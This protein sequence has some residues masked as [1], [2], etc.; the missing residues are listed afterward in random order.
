MGE[1]LRLFV[2]EY[3]RRLV[4]AGAI[5]SLF[6]SVTNIVPLSATILL[7]VPLVVLLYRPRMPVQSVTQVTI[8][9]LV[10]LLL[11]GLFYQ[12]ED[13]ARFTFYRFD[14][15]AFTIY[16]LLLLLSLARTALNVGAV[17][18]LFVWWV[19]I[20][21]AV[22]IA[23][24]LMTGGTVWFHEPGIYHFLFRAHNA[25]GGFLMLISALSIGLLMKYRRWLYLVPLLANL[26][27]LHLTV[28]RG[29]MLALAG[30]SL[31]VLLFGI[32]SR[33][34]RVTV[35]AL[36]MLQI[37]LMTYLFFNA[38][39]REAVIG[40]LPVLGAENDN[41]KTHGTLMRSGTIQ[42]RTDY[43]WPKAIYLWFERP[44]FGVG[45]G[46][47]NDHIACASSEGRV[48][49]RDTCQMYAQALNNT[50]GG[51]HNNFF[52]EG[53][54]EPSDISGVCY[55]H[56][57]SD[58]NA[59]HSFLQ[60]L[61]E[62]GLLG[63]S[64][65]LALLYFIWRFLNSTLAGAERTGMILAFWAVLLSAFAENQLFAPAQMLPFIIILG[66]YIAAANYERDHSR[67]D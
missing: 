27:G 4:V 34:G 43:L 31:I 26:L 53:E 38:P 22:F 13:F 39:E 66:L 47:Y 48:G 21:N 5:A 49:G 63:L 50:G 33:L 12:W 18:R 19:T 20:I 42:I 37:V 40:Y 61:A 45:L 32:S 24:Y 10:V 8:L 46:G 25:A 6:L 65:F 35:G 29:S 17:V 1:V 16:S 57:H 54:P 55:M 52:C 28:S 36:F 44:L 59:H 3:A 14:G 51:R 2:S 64:V 23:I 15:V 30:A 67:V 7:L 62:T 58:S 41:V 11:S 60:L 56:I 9:F